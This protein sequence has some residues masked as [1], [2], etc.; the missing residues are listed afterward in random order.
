[1]DTKKRFKIGISFRSSQREKIV[2]P[3]C[4]ALCDMGFTKTDIFYDEWHRDEWSGKESF[5][6][7]YGNRCDMVV[8]L[9]TSDYKDSKWTADAEWLATRNLIENYE[10]N[11]KV[12]ILTPGQID[13]DSKLFNGMDKKFVRS[14]QLQIDLDHAKPSEIAK[15][16]KEKYDSEIAIP[17]R[18]T[19]DIQEDIDHKNIDAVLAERPDKADELVSRIDRLQQNNDIIPYSWI[20][21]GYWLGGIYERG[22]QYDKSAGLAHKFLEILGEEGIT[23]RISKY[24]SIRFTIGLAYSLAIAKSDNNS[25]RKANL[26]EAEKTYIE[27]LSDGKTLLEEIDDAELPDVRKFELRGLYY[28]DYAAFRINKGQFLKD[29]HESGYEDEFEKALAIHKE[30]VHDREKYLELAETE[31]D[32]KD[33]K[34][35]LL[36][37]KS[38][39]ANV[40]FHMG[41]YDEA[42]EVHK[43]IVSESESTARIHILSETYILGSYI[44]KWKLE[45]SISADEEKEFLYYLKDSKALA[46]DSE[47]LLRDITDK[48]DQYNSLKHPDSDNDN[49]DFGND[50]KDK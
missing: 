2:L 40:L 46:K 7:I 6:D 17:E 22:K 33:A 48:E 26:D 21:Y 15:K 11:E 29:N 24:H 43:E 41:R 8:V 39:V 37:S 30:G 32:K 4:E 38:N 1:M 14:M 28:S 27:P 18:L 3:I 5:I 25:I 13:F 31:H 16:I 44:C 19:R 45:K 34:A 23:K 50:E 12:Y 35:R 10:T 9:F 20:N 36:Q 42:I 49:R 47:T